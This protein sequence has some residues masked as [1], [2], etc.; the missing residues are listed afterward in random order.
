[1]LAPMGGMLGF[2]RTHDY[3]SFLI[4]AIV[5][6]VAISLHEFGHAF[7]AEW[8]GDP[9][10]RLAGRVT[11][12]PARH[13]D[14]FGT[15]MLVLVGFGWGKPVP[16]S[17]ANMRHRRWG[18]AIVGAAGPA[19]NVLQALA[20]AGLARALHLPLFVGIGGLPGYSFTDRLV[21]AFLYLNILLALFNLIPVPPLDGSRVLSA[22]LPPNRQRVIYFLD[23]WGFL[24]LLFA[25][26][27]G[28][29]SGM[30]TLA[31]HAESALLR[32]FGY[33]VP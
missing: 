20:A 31:I 26:L 5:F 17:P 21:G 6:V 27:L 33:T 2:L 4:L 10:A 13:L 24:I 25:A 11:L 23:Q 14:V 9:T 15:I 29:L 8:E 28:A 32:V 19:M 16:I 18:A 3:E 30:A 22:F 7:V 1:M 12:N